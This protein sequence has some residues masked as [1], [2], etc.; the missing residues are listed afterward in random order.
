[1]HHGGP[2]VH[3]H[4]SERV[5]GALTF[6]ITAVVLSTAG[7]MGPAESATSA[8]NADA[9]SAQATGFIPVS[10]PVQ[11]AF[12]QWPLPS[13]AEHYAD[14]DGRH[15]LEFVV[16]QV[17]ISRRYRDQVHPKYWGRIIGTSSDAE[18]A[19]WLQ[20][21]FEAI[22]LSDVRIQPFDLQPQWMPRSYEVSVT[23]GGT[24]LELESAQ[25]V[26]RAVGTPPEGLE[27]EAAYV[28]LGTEADFLGR[29]VQGKAVFSYSMFGL[30]DNGALPRADAHGAAA[31]FDVHMLPG[32]MRYQ[33][34]PK[35]T[36]VPTFTVGGDDGFAV[37][38]LIAA[39]PPGQPVRVSV[40]MDVEIV[41]DL[42]TA[43]VWGTLP[44]AT[45]E[46]IY[47]LAH[48]DGWFDASG[49]NASGVASMIGLAEHY[50]RIPQSERRRT[51]VFLGID[52]HHNSG[53]GAGV[54][55]QWLLDNRAEL[56]TQTA[57]MINVEHPSTVQTS[58]RPRYASRT[59]QGFG[60]GDGI[61]WS[62]TYTGQQWYA[63]GP[64]RPE[65]QEITVGAF[66]EFGVSYYLEPNATAPA[67]DL[68]RLFR[69]VPGVASTDF[70]H[71]FHTDLETPE[72][73]PWTGL[74]ATTRAY[75]RIIDEVNKHDLGVFQRPE[76]PGR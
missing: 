76:E 24:T 74:E 31:I 47:I 50:A 41:P 32:N 30:G 70:Y 54:G 37:R 28:G 60:Y 43:I 8:Q 12:L 57:L 27:L 61:F 52:G 56:F 26:Y 25:P 36:S 16:E 21:K 14:I 75:A 34:Y 22:D 35:N 69:V 18:S 53:A 51:L 33:A 45:E 23:A 1:M 15:M 39:A 20:D 38:D 44:G 58:S 63:G 5:E 29:D 9:G 62:N 3:H 67:G 73:V 13:G 71:Y 48:R 10:G 68:S 66:R 19:E 46:T 2:P 72:T 49:D 11:E 17:E 59:A 55:R 65:L 4:A 40:R 64:S 42:Q 6:T 7:C